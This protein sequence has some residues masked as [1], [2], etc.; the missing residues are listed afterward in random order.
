MM[1]F[2]FE[3]AKCF[4]LL[5]YKKLVEEKFGMTLREYN[6]KKYFELEDQLSYI[7][8]FILWENS[9]SQYFRL[10][11]NFRTGL[12]SGNSFVDEFFDLFNA[13]QKLLENFVFNS[14]NLKN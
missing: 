11:T 9:F 13:D 2:D 12:I 6:L 14:E 10:F 1:T 7:K 4:K 5:N 8:D 3:K